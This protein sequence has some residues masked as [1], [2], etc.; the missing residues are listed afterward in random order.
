MLHEHSLKVNNVQNQKKLHI[1]AALKH[2][3]AE[4][5]RTVQLI[6]GTQNVQL[7]FDSFYPQSSK[8]HCYRR[9]QH[10]FRPVIVL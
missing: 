7:N 10:P 2:S 4:K 9:I 6:H 3:N 1:H 5:N 8:L